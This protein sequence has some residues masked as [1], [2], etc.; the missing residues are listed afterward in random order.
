MLNAGNR[1]ESN[2]WLAAIFC[3]RFAGKNDLVLGNA[4]RRTARSF[5]TPIVV[6]ARLSATIVITAGLAA[7]GR[8][9]FG[10]RQIASAARAARRAS[11]ARASATASP[12]AATAAIATTVSTPICASVTT[13]PK[14]L[15]GTVAGAAGRIVLRGVVM[16]RKVL[17]SGSVGI[18]LAFLGRFSVLVVDGSGLVFVAMLL[19]TFA[20]GGVRLLVRS[21]RLI[22]VLGF[23][24]MK[25]FV[26]GFFVKFRG[27]SQGFTRE[28]FDGRTDRG[29]QRRS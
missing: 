29:G 18:G 5:G 23:V 27:A 26:L 21:V 10:W 25:L 19:E 13:A 22:R 15:A 4:W 8:C 17:R 7:L 6:A 28:Y 11:A 2:N 20:F 16:G 9:I 1:R 24:V 14:V 12:T 3:Q